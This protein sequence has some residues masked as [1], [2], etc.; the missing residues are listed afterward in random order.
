MVETQHKYEKMALSDEEAEK[1]LTRYLA[2]V[3]G[4]ARRTFKEE[5]NAL[6]THVSGYGVHY[7]DD[8]KFF[9]YLRDSYLKKTTR[10]AFLEQAYL[11][12]ITSRRVT[13]DEQAKFATILGPVIT[14]ILRRGNVMVHGPIIL[15]LLGMFDLQKKEDP[16]LGGLRREIRVV[17]LPSER[18]QIRA[19]LKE[20]NIEAYATNVHADNN[21]FDFRFCW[22]D[23]HVIVHYEKSPKYYIFK[24][25]FSHLR[26]AYDGQFLLGY[27]EFVFERKT[28]VDYQALKT[29]V[30]YWRKRN[31][32]IL[33]K[34]G[35]EFDDTER[36]KKE[37]ERI[38]IIREWEHRPCENWRDCKREVCPCKRPKYLYFS[39]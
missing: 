11:S 30:E 12:S 35:N 17:A 13:R 10:E 5:R 27:G 25:Y 22:G 15:T 37:D 36:Q 26:F 39:G 24:N 23:I 29:E 8:E 38:E 33:D 32:V 1:T 18:D 16:S 28:R 2:F 7:Q 4:E 3:E 34:D 21:E 20:Y 31:Y 6:T 14:R 19:T 9:I